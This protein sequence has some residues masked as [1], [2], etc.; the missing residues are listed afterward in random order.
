MVA[1]LLCLAT[2]IMPAQ[3]ANFLKGNHVHLTS[4][5]RIDGDVYAAGETVTVDG[6]IDGD[7]LAAGGSVTCAGEITGSENVAAG[8]FSHTGRVDGSIRVFCSEA[9]IE[10]YVGRSVLFVGSILKV[11]QA[12][13]IRKDINAY[14]YRVDLAGTVMG[15]VKIKAE[16]IKISGQ[17]DGDVVLDADESIVIRAPAV[18][19]GNLT[20]SSAEEL[21]LEAA[22]VTVLGEV[23]RLEPKD[24]VDAADQEAEELTD[25]VL[26][27]SRLFAAFLFGLILIWLC[28]TYLQEAF[29]QL[30]RRFMV[31][32][33]TGL[34]AAAAVVMSAAV[35]LV[36]IILSVVGLIMSSG[37]QAAGGAVLL[38]FST[39]MVPITSFTVVT[40]GV[41]FYA[42]KLLPAFLVGYGLIRIFK[43]QP[44]QLGKWQLLIGLAFMSGFFAIPLV[45]LLF[46][47]AA[48]IIGAGAIILGIKNCHRNGTKSLAVP[49][50]SQPGNPPPSTP[51]E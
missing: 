28:P 51:K 27:F 38:I 12:A 47:L 33:A 15:N 21:D 36:A 11:G 6:S 9:E 31:S 44:R 41:L 46:Y 22:G 50:L 29:T 5:H 26:R 17:I 40:G 19:R 24:E 7:L 45:G 25:T 43:H 4:L 16:R 10:G 20:Y 13:I 1:T 42:G 34:L 3:A 23:T 18:I 49:D 14:G 30:R 48:G 8:D 39:L 32:V 37:D 2:A 35:L